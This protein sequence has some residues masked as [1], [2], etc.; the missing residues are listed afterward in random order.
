MENEKITVVAMDDD[1]AILDIYDVGLFVK[2]YDVK[3]F[4]DPVKAREYILADNPCDI[5]LTDI[6]M[7]KI[8]GITMIK[9]LHSNPKTMNIPIIAV[10]GLNDAKT[11][12]TVLAAGAVDYVVKP[13]NID[14]LISKIEELCKGKKRSPNE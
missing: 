12:E 6:M 9:E 13:F 1:E 4:L 7:P 2:G 14:A 5:I 11:L 3:S 10:S 8:D